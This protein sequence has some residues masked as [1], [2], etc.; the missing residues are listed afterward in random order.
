VQLAQDILATLR[1]PRLSGTERSMI[2]IV[3]EAVASR[4][5]EA[6]GVLISFDAVFNASESELSSIHHLGTHGVREINGSDKKLGWSPTTDF[7]QPSRILKVLYLIQR[8]EEKG[9]IPQTADNIAKLMAEQVNTDL[10]ALRNNVTNG[11]E[12]LVSASM[13]STDGEFYHFLSQEEREIEQYFLDRKGK[14]RIPDLERDIKDRGRV[15]LAPNK[16]TGGTQQYQLKYGSSGQGLFGFET[17]LDGE[18]ISPPGGGPL[19]LELYTPISGVK[20]DQLRTSNLAEGAQGKTVYWVADGTRKTELA[21]TLRQI[22]ALEE[23]INHY[24]PAGLKMAL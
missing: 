7:A 13:V 23:T 15:I 5:E 24:Q 8:L 19:Y 16:I 2:Q 11:L 17:R 1:G 3:Q 21:E 9:W 20:I 18:V 4:C 6:L 22:R 10:S 12:K 14:V